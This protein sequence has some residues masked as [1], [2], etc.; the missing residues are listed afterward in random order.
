[1]RH[2][3]AMAQ[4]PDRPS[5]RLLVSIHDVTPRFEREIDRLCDLLAGILGGPRFAML[6]VPNH[7]GDQSLADNPAFQRRLRA[8]A[9]EGVEMFVHGWFHRDM[10]EHRGAA[11]LKARYMTAGEGEFL[12]LAEDVARRRMEDGKALVEHIIGRPAAGFIAPAWLYGPGAMAALAQSNFALAEDHMRVW[13]PADGRRIAWG[14][15]VTWASRSR[16]RTAS[17]IAFA[18]LARTGLR[19]LRNVRLAVHPPDVTKAAL[20]HSIA[21]TTRKLAKGR[22]IA[23]YAD[24]TPET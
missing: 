23:R 1:M 21:A 18:A 12:G 3:P 7:W 10:A 13:R 15:V 9:D 22:A 11:G 20:I 24:L 14:P 8:W 16:A 5:K 4:L 6:V 19:P 2:A 17:S